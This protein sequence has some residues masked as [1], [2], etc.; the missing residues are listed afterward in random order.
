MLLEWTTCIGGEM[1]ETR[2]VTYKI[3][4][5]LPNYNIFNLA[6]IKNNQIVSEHHFYS[7]NEAKDK[8]EGHH[9]HELTSTNIDVTELAQ[10]PKC[11]SDY[12]KGYNEGYNNSLKDLTALVKRLA[13]KNR[14]LE[15]DHLSLSQDKAKQIEEIERLNAINLKL[16]TTLDKIVESV[17][18]V[19]PDL[20]K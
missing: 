10:Q 14:I 7:I 1:A 8:A 20:Q 16:V 5:Y 6:V 12:D 4:K 17:E 11:L 13:E 19:L 15:D 18:K 9:L 2:N 3:T